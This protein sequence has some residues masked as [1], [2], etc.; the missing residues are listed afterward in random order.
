MWEELAEG[1]EPGMG[2]WWWAV[3]AERL[4]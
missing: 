1:E 3:S 4:T 2:F